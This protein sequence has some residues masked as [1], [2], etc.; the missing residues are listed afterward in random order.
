MVESTLLFHLIYFD[1][2]GH[3]SGTYIMV[4]NHLHLVLKRQ[5]NNNNLKIIKYYLFNTY[6]NVFL[7]LLMQ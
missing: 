1:M 5:P 6:N 4:V 3:L 2:I 7:L